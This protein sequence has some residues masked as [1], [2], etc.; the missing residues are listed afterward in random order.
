MGEWFTTLYG[1]SFAPFGTSH[2]IVLFIYL[3]G[4]ILL[5]ITYKKIISSNYLY[6]TLRWFFFSLLILSELG[7]Q[8]WSIHNGIWSLREYIP[9]HLCGIASIIAAA[10]LATHNKKLIYITFFIGLI[11]SLLALITPELPYGYPHFRFWKL[12]IHHIAISWVSIF[13][14]ATN[15]IKITFKAMVETYGYLLIY[16]AIIGFLINPW[17]N[18]NY[19]YLSTTPTTSTPLDLLGSGFWYYV[20]LCLLGLIVLIGQ[21]GLYKLFKKVSTR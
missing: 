9:L 14:V 8:A 4:I 12:F 20:N 18:S 7:Y 6:N 3:A 21:F 11:P 2:L 10:A 1:D 17:L 16:A 5:L 13:L 15:P 19:L